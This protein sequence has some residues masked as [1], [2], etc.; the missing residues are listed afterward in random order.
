MV[1]VVKERL[2]EGT[3]VPGLKKGRTDAAI[4]TGD[5]A[6]GCQRSVRLDSQGLRDKAM[7]GLKVFCKGDLLILFLRGFRSLL[8][9]FVIELIDL[10]C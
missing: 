8:F 3:K 1:Y 7:T 9:L 5:C 6:L 2:L 4:W 10:L